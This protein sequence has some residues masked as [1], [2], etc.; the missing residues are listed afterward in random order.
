MPGT[1][2]SRFLPITGDHAFRWV[3]ELRNY[4]DCVG[5]TSRIITSLAWLAR[6][7]ICRS[8]V[9]SGIPA[10]TGDSADGHVYGVCT[11]C[12]SVR[13]GVYLI[14]IGDLSGN[15]FLG[16]TA[17]FPVRNSFQLTGDLVKSPVN[18]QVP[19]S[20]VIFCVWVP[21]SQQKHTHPYPHT[22]K[23]SLDFFFFLIYLPRCRLEFFPE[24]VCHSVPGSISF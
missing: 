19:S 22:N 3:K 20:W 11:V 2:N 12:V 5:L 23:S 4:T 16:I 15:W 24:Y 1:G 6:L 9:A 17:V 18:S 7:I 21:S 8:A 13:S 10:V 14:G